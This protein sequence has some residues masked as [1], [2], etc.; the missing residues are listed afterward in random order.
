MPLCGQRV[1]LPPPWQVGL[2]QPPHTKRQV[3][4]EHAH[5]PPTPTSLAWHSRPATAPAVP[6]IA[7]DSPTSAISSWPPHST[8]TAPAGCTVWPTTCRARSGGEVGQ[9]VMSACM[10]LSGC[11]CVHA[12]QQPPATAWRRGARALHDMAH[13]PCMNNN[14]SVASRAPMCLSQMAHIRPL[15]VLPPSSPARRHHPDPR[16]Q[17]SMAPPA[18]GTLIYWPAPAHP[19][20]ALT[21]RDTLS[22]SHTIATSTHTC[23]PWPLCR[24]ASM[25]CVRAARKPPA[26][27]RCRLPVGLLDLHVRCTA[28][29][30]PAQQ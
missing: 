2:V 4:P 28:V 25:S 22:S 7:C 26:C 1:S 16:A 15:Y 23:V 18:A 17:P 21:T 20:P 14:L 10:H 13:L 29:L 6:P 19:G 9:A 11:R 12:H 24:V 5:T 27:V 3:Q 30:V 8:D